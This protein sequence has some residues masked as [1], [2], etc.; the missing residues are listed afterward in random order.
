MRFKN[1]LVF[2]LEDSG[3]YVQIKMLD[4]LEDAR[5]YVKWVSPSRLPFILKAKSINKGT[6]IEFTEV[7]K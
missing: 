3:K 5:R 2:C 6:V 7:V 1:Y 4:D